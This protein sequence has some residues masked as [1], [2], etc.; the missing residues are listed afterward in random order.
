[1]DLL[2]SG[3]DELCRRQLQLLDRAAPS[4]VAGTHDR[5][6]RAT[7]AGLMAFSRL[8]SRSS[9]LGTFVTQLVDLLADDGRYRFLEAIPD[10]P[11]T[12]MARAAALERA[13]L[14]TVTP[15][16]EEL[17]LQLAV[18]TLLLD[19]L[20]DEVPGELVPA[21]TWLAAAMEP[22]SWGRPLPAPPDGLSPLASTLCQLATSV[23]TTITAGD[24][25]RRDPLLRAE[26]STAA[27]LAFSAELA[28]VDITFGGRARVDDV[29]S[30]VLGK[31]TYPI[32]CG[33]LLPFCVHGWPTGL[34]PIAFRSL[35]E[36]IG[37]F[38]GWIDDVVDVAEDLRSDRWST[39]LIEI[40]ALAQQ[41]GVARSAADPRPTLAAVLASPLVIDRLAE[42]GL[43]RW[44]A[45]IDELEKLG[46]AAEHIRP[47]LY[48]MARACLGNRSQRLSA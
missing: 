46:L 47:A 22:Q 11:V 10:G 12:A 25:W 43:R 33:A 3:V 32:W 20:L 30:R 42:G 16:V 13:V 1:M 15:E 40:D 7:G 27:S 14:G 19:G 28:S 17:A 35:A 37:A 48:D 38:G 2:Q 9:T 21:A 39:V 36:R 29:Q 4:D 44:Q 26:F 18:F 45:V 41:L 23:I 8:Q 24:A 34:D 31:S 6:S 5:Q